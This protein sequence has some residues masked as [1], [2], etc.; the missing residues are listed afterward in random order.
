MSNYSYW[1][2]LLSLYWSFNS[3]TI[4]SLIR[5]KKAFGA[6]L[7]VYCS[8][9]ASLWGLLLRLQQ[10][11]MQLSRG[12]SR[13]LE[14]WQVEEYFH[15]FHFQIELILDAN[16]SLRA[17]NCCLSFCLL[18]SCPKVRYLWTSWGHELESDSSSWK[19]DCLSKIVH[20]EMIANISSRQ[21]LL[22]EINK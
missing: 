5:K 3:M 9:L 18:F 12:M 1:K 10:Y 14:T 7:S 4:F 16:H 22:M 2:D 20:V 21:G 13:E 19:M 17:Y 15:S 6:V 8:M 11:S